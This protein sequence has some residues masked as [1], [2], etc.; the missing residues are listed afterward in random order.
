MCA[1]HLILFF[2]AW[3]VCS[4]LIAQETPFRHQIETVRKPWTS[5]DFDNDPQNFQFAIVSDRTGGHRAGVFGKA[6]EKLN[7]LHPEFVMS[8]G[9]LIEGY[10]EDTSE[11]RAQWAEFDSIQAVL[12]MR[13]FALPG[14]HDISNDVMRNLW[15]ERYAHSYYHFR[16]RD[17]L[18]LAF[19]S[20]DG[21]GIDFSREQ[22]DYFKKAIRDNEDVR[23]TMV[24]MHHPVWNYREF[25][26]FDEI[27]A[28]LEDRPYTVV[29]G[30]N[31]RYFK[32]VRQ[33]RNY[34]IL[35]ST[36]GG[37]KLRGPRLG[38]FDHITWVTMTDEGP[39]LVHLQL[40]GILAD[41]VLDAETAPLA[42]ALFNAAQW[43]PLVLRKSEREA[44]VYLRV[45]N[46]LPRSRSEGA[47]RMSYPGSG[48]DDLARVQKPLRFSGQFYHNHHIDPSRGVIELRVDP[49]SSGQV[50]F[51]LDMEEGVALAEMDAPAMEWTLQFDGP[52]LEPPFKLSGLL[53]IPL[54]YS[55]DELLSFT[56]MDVFLDNH[57][58]EMEHG[59][60][61]IELRYTLDGTAPT[62][63][64]P[65]YEGPISI[66]ETTTVKAR[67]FE[68]G[69]QAASDV[70]E[71]IYRKVRPYPATVNK[72]NLRPGRM[73]YAYYEGMFSRLPDFDTL[74]AKKEGLTS[75][76]DV[77]ALAEREDH[78][79]IQ[80]EGY[81]E[82]PESGVYILA[83]RSDD[84]SKVYLQ[85]E[86]VVEN[87]GSHSARTR[88]GNVA[89][90]QGLHPIRIEYFEDYSGETLSLGMRGPDGKEVPL[91][92]DRLFIEK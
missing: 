58:V 5:L 17:V 25:N 73:R 24:F 37:S 55:I 27:E 92:F 67:L 68:P 82:V 54:A 40:R 9:D 61:G 53:D 21:D 86:L 39:E 30:H 89:L 35:A 42:T 3:A 32:N 52:E 14:N 49:Q 26:G 51:E 48:M 65:L 50:R 10:I 63:Q 76:F 15:L 64:S 70:K 57:Q 41:N 6:M 79:A 84:G 11:L 34:Y 74:T 2:L 60:R 45:E 20:N 69:G 13:F 38:E 75:D 19:D 66:S 16:Y 81:L 46:T 56:P 90:A 47:S 12:N 71:K 29:A 80:F 43:Q 87:D 8:V 28:A 59:F 85:D 36:G 22:L 91:E 4:S 72:E 18:F 44:V 1:K 31:H 78:F 23:W 33:D 88:R 7:L 62:Q 77:E 83:V